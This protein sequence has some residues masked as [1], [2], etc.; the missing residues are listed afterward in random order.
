MTQ[1]PLTQAPQTIAPHALPQGWSEAFPGGL[2]CSAD[3]IT[4]GIIDSVILSGE[5]FVIFNRDDLPMLDGFTSRDEAIQ[6]CVE[7]IGS[8]AA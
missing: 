4:G 7:H 3:P 2:A 6:A 8:L 5:W 1:A